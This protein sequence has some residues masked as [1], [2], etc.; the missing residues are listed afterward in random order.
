MGIERIDHEFEQY[1]LDN[2]LVLYGEAVNDEFMT[3]EY[4]VVQLASGLHKVLRKSG[5]ERII[6]FKLRCGCFF[7]DNDSMSLSRPQGTASHVRSSG[8]LGKRQLGAKK[9]PHPQL[10]NNVISDERS[11]AIIDHCMRDASI[12]TAVIFMDAQDIFSHID[13]RRQLCSQAGD[14]LGLISPNR[15]FCCWVFSLPDL[16]SV[17]NILKPNL[18]GLY[19]RIADNTGKDN[20]TC[21][22]SIRISPP[23]TTEIQRLLTRLRLESQVIYPFNQIDKLAAYFG[24]RNWLL[25]HWRAQFTKYGKVNKEI[26]VQR[27]WIESA[28]P[29]KTAWER[30]SEMIGLDSVKNRISG[31]MQV[32]KIHAQKKLGSKPVLHMI[33]RGN[34][35]T[36]KTTVARLLGELYREI[37]ALKRGHVREVASLSE[38]VAEY[39]GGTSPKMNQV[40]DEAL[41][42][43]LFIDEAYQLGS[44][45]AFARQALETLL[46]RLENDSDRLAVILAGYPDDMDNLL[47]TNAGLKRR[48]PTII[49]FE[50]Y[51]P[52][53]LETILKRFLEEAKLSPSAKMDKVLFDVVTGMHIMR[54]KTFGNAGD[55]RNLS[56]ALFLNWSSRI[57]KTGDLGATL[58]PIDLPDTY[59]K[60]LPTG[61]SANTP[62]QDM[63]SILASMDELTGLEEVKETLRSFVTAFM[64]QKKIGASES[65]NKNIIFLGNPGTG[66]TTVARILGKLFR[67]IGALKKGH[68]EEI[69]SL[70]KI[71]AEHVGGTSPLMDSEIDKAM[72]GVLFIDEAYQLG[73]KD[74]PHAKQALETLLPRLENDRDR[75]SVILAGYSKEMEDLLKIN[76]GLGSRFPTM[77]RFRD[78]TPAE[79]LDILKKFLAERKLKVSTEMCFV[80]ADCVNG[81]YARRDKH[82]GNA[83]SMR[84][85]ADALL[86]RWSLRIGIDG[87]VKTPLDPADLPEDYA[88]YVETGNTCRKDKPEDVDAILGELDKMVGMTAIRAKLETIR[89]AIVFDKARGMPQTYTR[90]LIFSG[91]PGTGK[92]TVAHMIARI[93]HALGCLAKDTC[94][95]VSPA[96]IFGQYVGETEQ[97]AQTIFEKAKGG[98]LFIDEAYSCCSHSYGTDFITSLVRFMDANRDNTAV[99]IAGYPDKIDDVLAMN[100]GLSSRFKN[101]NRIEFPDYTPSELAE[102]VSRLSVEQNIGLDETVKN[103]IMARMRI[104]VAKPGFGNGRTAR[105]LFEDM[106][107]RLAARFAKGDVDCGNPTFSIADVPD[108]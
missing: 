67:E 15:N 39:V 54:D 96:E 6:F 60:Y 59:R 14:W 32:M 102:I 40:I 45:D 49:D 2:G 8:V 51:N 75:L 3:T 22:T 19:T 104:D 79:L 20:G 77:V 73:E 90:H 56:Q 52:A 30:L 10:T 24:A 106:K 68:T 66:K 88:T 103:K 53:Q 36:G 33:F 108:A 91:N 47:K 29:D 94:E 83:R 5:F 18:P 4:T 12:R 27:K 89:N 92:T 38:I 78:F 37:G 23:Q 57:G 81:M 9:N 65:P 98:V 99:I 58:E 35:G 21:R 55:M 31:Q 74:N 1:A 28:L 107:E 76:P 84:N 41:D 80:L 25:R 101:S 63:D 70:S 69:S 26:A 100:E 61:Q 17:C 7:Y 93:Y 105:N 34:P 42:G 62:P 50:D 43:V 85:L 95:D 16:E 11:L 64:V 82:F 44:N 97:K 87:D 46:T 72:D 86:R 71:V 13:S 48:F